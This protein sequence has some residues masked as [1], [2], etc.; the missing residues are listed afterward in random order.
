VAAVITVSAFTRREL[1][2]EFGLKPSSVRVIHDCVP[3][4]LQR[5]PAE[6][7][8]DSPTILVVGTAPHKNSMR[9]VAAVEGT[10]CR[11]LFIGRV[12]DALLRKLTSAGV[13]FEEKLN[14]T[15]EGLAE[16]YRRADLVYFASTYEGFGLPIVE[17]QTVGRPV[18]TS[19]ICSMPEVAGDGALFVDPYDV[20]DIRLALQ[21][22]FA[23]A[24]L[25]A[26]LVEKGYSNVK[27]FSRAVFADAHLEVYGQIAAGR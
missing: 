25:R 9:L 10:R 5:S 26:E 23:S 4:G 14:L 13:E 16:C 12:Q 27:R 18:I 22:L 8:T 6:F 3:A 24:D 20:K 15:N 1:I 7:K 21:K 2:R 11:I 19:R 17:A